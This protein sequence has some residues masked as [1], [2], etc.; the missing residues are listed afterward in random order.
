M[1]RRFDW[2]ATNAFHAAHSAFVAAVRIG[3]YNLTIGN[4][5][6]N[7]A[8]NMFALGIVDIFYRHPTATSFPAF[9]SVSPLL[10]NCKRCHPAQKMRRQL[11]D[12]IAFRSAE[13]RFAWR[14]EMASRPTG[15]LI[16]ILSFRSHSGRTAP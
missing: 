9:V 2:T 8:F 10:Y 3:A 1:S 4:L 5:F 15:L 16:R 14:A 6:G 11:K 12:A 7:N 13:Q